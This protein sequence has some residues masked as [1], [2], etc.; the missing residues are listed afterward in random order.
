MRKYFEAG[1]QLPA[2]NRLRGV[3]LRQ[4]FLDLAAGL[5]AVRWAYSAVTDLLL[6]GRFYMR[7]SRYPA[8]SAV[9]DELVL[10]IPLAQGAL[11][12]L[13]GLARTR[14][15]GFYGS[16]GMLCLTFLLPRSLR[17][18]W[19]NLACDV[20]LVAVALAAVLMEGKLRGMKERSA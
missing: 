20:G 18:G 12:L 9:A 8:W 19:G 4:L 3:L 16:F 13:L 17:D 10:T 2:A 11:V 15:A 1:F 6:P 7:L 14:L 5:L